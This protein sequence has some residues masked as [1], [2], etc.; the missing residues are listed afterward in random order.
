MPH[1]ILV[2]GCTARDQR[3][4]EALISELAADFA[5][6]IVVVA[7]APA[8]DGS[9]ATTLRGRSGLP[10]VEVQDKDSIVPGTIHLAPPDYHLLVEAGTFALST[11]APLHG[12][13]PSIDPLFES[14]ADAYGEHAVAVLVAGE[15]ADEEYADGMRGLARIRE[16]GG[17]ALMQTPAA[18]MVQL[19]GDVT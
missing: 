16:R 19:P 13:R 18:P 14:A 9:L 15:D 7:H 4:L 6:P 3:G 17:V 10:V 11:E 8:E 5:L 12:A 1:A 2:I